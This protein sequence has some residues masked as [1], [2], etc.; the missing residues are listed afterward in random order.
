MAVDSVARAIAV[1]NGSGGGGGGGGTSNYNDLSNKPS[2]NGVT[3]SGDKTTE[4]LGLPELN[5]NNYNIR[6]PLFQLYTDPVENLNYYTV[7]PSLDH[8]ATD[9]LYLQ[10]KRVPISREGALIEDGT[11]YDRLYINPWYTDIGVLYD[12]PYDEHNCYWIQNL[13][14]ES[15]RWMGIKRCEDRD[16][17]GFAYA[18]GIGNPST[19]DINLNYLV[20]FM[21]DL[22][23]ATFKLNSGDYNWTGIPFG[24]WYRT[25]SA[26]VS[27]NLYCLTDENC[28]NNEEYRYYLWDFS[29]EKSDAGSDNDLLTPLLSAGQE[30]NDDEYRLIYTWNVP[31]VPVI[32]EVDPEDNIPSDTGIYHKTTNNVEEYVL[33]NQKIA[34]ESRIMVTQNAS[35]EAGQVIVKNLVLKTDQPLNNP[36][37][38]YCHLKFNTTL[39]KEEVLTIL[40]RTYEG[41]LYDTAEGGSAAFGEDIITVYG[42]EGYEVAT[43][44]DA[45]NGWNPDTEK[46]LANI[47]FN[48]SGG[49]IDGD[50]SPLYPLISGDYYIVDNTSSDCFSDGTSGYN[51]PASPD[52]FLKIGREWLPTR[53]VPYDTYSEFYFNTDMTIQEVVSCLTTAFNSSHKLEEDFVYDVISA[54]PDN[55]GH[56][57]TLRIVY[58]VINGFSIVIHSESNE[59]E[60]LFDENNGGWSRYLNNFR[61]GK[62]LMQ[63]GDYSLSA[64]TALISPYKNECQYYFNHEPINSPLPSTETLNA[65]TY[66]LHVVDGIKPVGVNT[67]FNTLKFDMTL[68]LADMREW[69]EHWWPFDYASHSAIMVVGANGSIGLSVQRVYSTPSYSIFFKNSN[70]VSTTLYSSSNR[71]SGSWTSAAETTLASFEGPFRSFYTSQKDGIT[72]FGEVKAD[73]SWTPASG[74]DIPA[75]IECET[76]TLT[77]SGS[78]K[79]LYLTKDVVALLDENVSAP[80]STQMAAGMVVLCNDDGTNPTHITTINDTQISVTDTTNNSATAAVL[81]PSQLSIANASQT[82]NTGITKDGITI[83]DVTNNLSNVMTKDDS[84]ITNGHLSTHV[85][86]DRF[87]LDSNDSSDVVQLSLG[88]LSM[89]NDNDDASEISPTGATFVDADRMY[90]T[91]MDATGIYIT[92]TDSS[93]YSAQMDYNN[94]RF[95]QTSNSTDYSS[96]YGAGGFKA[97]APGLHAGSVEGS[98]DSGFKTTGTYSSK[99]CIGLLTPQMLQLTQGTGSQAKMIT[100]C[101]DNTSDGII[102]ARSGSLE[103]LMDYASM[104]LKDSGSSYNYQYTCSPEGFS[105]QGANQ[106][107]NYSIESGL[108]TS[109][110]TICTIQ[111]D[112]EAEEDHVDN[113]SNVKDNTYVGQVVM[114][115]FYDTGLTEESASVGIITRKG[116]TEWGNPALTITT[117]LEVVNM[118]GQSRTAY[119]LFID[120]SSGYAE[121]VEFDIADAIIINEVGNP[122][123][124]RHK[125]EIINLL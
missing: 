76:A 34:T 123:N 19:G 3:L 84:T 20:V 95:L 71:E 83:R 14:T 117:S 15:P 40:S 100:I 80:K 39:S 27:G 116:V 18:F 107:F 26:S 103:I 4:D 33:V 36:S 118:N 96:F 23:Y 12:L 121:L 46:I 102:T 81:T 79:T 120:L 90:E 115:R 68:S 57:A 54:D 47:Y 49:S 114:L 124:Q 2:I 92:D 58:S 119:R 91:R 53:L 21:T 72:L 43:I 85:K 70:N 35:G 48:S 65:G 77:E 30:F 122:S 9:T 104:S 16:G 29:H 99:S 109:K 97:T 32:H 51:K 98:A 8:S 25:P 88:Q 5:I 13:N 82:L 55:Y 31:V 45:E 111:Y 108:A 64:I 41:E 17:D 113:L 67:R 42:D 61:Y 7:L 110:F 24:M 37:T 52:D 105:C 73:T 62:W 87:R 112:A 6:S 22:E 50:L 44:F 74:G 125:V 1:K 28:L 59:D 38:F 60:I 89:S 10:T 101:P 94:M 86:C 78:D 11:N 75:N 56:E 93:A 69:L 66:N 63:S 106:F